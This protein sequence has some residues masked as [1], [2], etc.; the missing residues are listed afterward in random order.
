MDWY[1]AQGEGNDMTTD[2]A[3]RRR[4]FDE[5]VRLTD[6]LCALVPGGAHTYAKGAD[7]YPERMAP[8]IS[9]GA[10]AHVWDVDGNRY[11]EYG[12][13]LRSVA[14]GHAHPEVDAAAAHA[15]SRGTNFC[16][17]T[18]LEV[19]AAETMLSVVP[20][21]DMVKFAKNG[22][23]ATTAA[24]RLARAA[25]GRDL[26]AVCRDHP[27]F[28]VDDWF[29][30]TS[31]MNAGI[32]RAV[33]DMTLTFGYG[34][35]DGVRALLEAHHGQIACLFL[36]GVTQTEPDPQ[37]FPG[38]RRLCDDHG[39]LLVVDEMINGFRLA[40]G[41][42]Q[43][44]HPVR[45]DLS[46]FGKAMGNGFAVSAL[47][48]RRELMRLGGMDHDEERV[49]LLSTTHG[50]ETHALA[51]AV[52]V[53]DVYRRDHV[54]DR[55]VAIGTLLRDRVREAVAAAGVADHVT[56]HGYPQNLVY[57]TLDAQGRRSQEFRTLFLQELLDRGVLAPS[58]V[59]SAAL[60]E[61]D[62]TRTADAVH[63]AGL[64]YRRAL[65]DGVETV[66]RGRPVQP[67]IRA[68]G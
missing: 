16:R 12:S 67:A 40:L 19:R 49:F 1:R 58:F 60:T 24:L 27:F 2:A 20:D 39:T 5:S 10:G 14:L 55:L 21:A 42:A 9:H 47:L 65:D 45:P 53:V 33:R 38:L 56:L 32:P 26:V 8:V 44:I 54:V 66:L 57:A 29:I 23:D 4:V 30:G 15:I 36:E 28:S 13:G 68:R 50:A 37:W 22:S 63:E 31:A 41:G 48:G 11:V 51:A 34:D 64:V 7:Q 35:L 52:A 61:E 43:E 46:T 18:A 17:P 62:V 25:T 6:R 59:V 3:A